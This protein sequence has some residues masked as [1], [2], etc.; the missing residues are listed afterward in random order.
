MDALTQ[1]SWLLLALGV[2]SVLLAANALRPRRSALLLVP[3][4]FAAWWTTE[5]P[6]H[7]IVLTG[8]VDL[9]LLHAGALDRPVG[10]IG[11][12]LLLLAWI[13]LAHIF[14]VAGRA[15]AALEAAFAVAER[16]LPPAHPYPRAHLL[17]PPLMFWRRDVEVRRGVP[18]AEAGDQTL[19]LDI[20]RPRAPGVR[21]PAIVQVHG[22]AW[23]IG[24]KE[25]QGIPLLTHLA[26]NGWV[27]FNV[28]YRLSPRATFP[29]HLIDVKRAVAW[30]RAHAD[31]LG[32]DPD[33]I[34]VTGGSAG[35]HLSALMALTADDPEYQP[36]FEGADTTVQAAV[37]FYGVFDFTNRRRPK[38]GTYRA[39]LER[40]IMKRPMTDEDAYARASP[41]ER[42]HEAAPPVFVIHG[43]QD[44]LAPV[45][46]ARAFVEHLRERSEDLVLYA[47]L[48]GAAHAFDIFPSTRTVVVIEAVERFLEAILA[49]HRA[50]R[51]RP[52]GS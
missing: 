26:A 47:E 2:G 17:V 12:G 52:L 43:D 3:S 41:I 30:I 23:V 50:G 10:V 32:V 4:F 15:E 13:G 24:F 42:V 48:P 40:V 28:D 7:L 11:Q 22:G 18:F 1:P 51:R 33:F 37:V 44:N 14:R 5:L 27:G 49:E 19:R 25:Y 45:K 34:V 38:P 21:R 20:Y 35:G 39:L 36:G 16:P 46:E 6:L 29:D 8:A 31:E 9:L